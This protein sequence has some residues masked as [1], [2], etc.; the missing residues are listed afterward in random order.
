MTA[1]QARDIWVEAP[2]G[3]AM[4]A[5]EARCKGVGT[6]LCRYALDWAREH[7]Y[8]GMQFN[9]VVETN[10]T[11]VEIYKRL[12]FTVIGTVPGAFEH[13]V[14]GR[15]GLHIMFCPCDEDPDRA[16]LQ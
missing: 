13:P 8:A 10:V 5:G 12:G 15:V 11:A 7:G 9:A 6:A 2:P 1:E 14:Q 3:H 16:G 4:V